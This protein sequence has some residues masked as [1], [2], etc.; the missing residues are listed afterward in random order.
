MRHFGTR[1]VL[2][3]II[4]LEQILFFHVELLVVSL[5]AGVIVLLP[6]HRQ[7]AL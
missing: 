4:E 2:M 1:L 6:D 3:I 5:E 7:I